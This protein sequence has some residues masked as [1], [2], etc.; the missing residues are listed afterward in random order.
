MGDG[1]RLSLSC[2]SESDESCD[3]KCY[4]IYGTDGWL[5]ELSI[6]VVIKEMTNIVC[7]ADRPFLHLIFNVK[8]LKVIKYYLYVV[9]NP[10]K[11][12]GIMCKKGRVV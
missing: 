10:N 11:S 3:F 9:T 7:N 6:L 1:W 8:T 12:K 4:F 5:G 2:I